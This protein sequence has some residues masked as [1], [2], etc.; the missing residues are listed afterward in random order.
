MHLVVVHFNVAS[1]ISAP[2]LEH[3]D[4]FAKLCIFHLNLAKAVLRTVQLNI[5]FFD[6]AI[7]LF[8]LL[9]D[10]GIVAL[11]GALQLDAL[12]GAH[13]ELGVLLA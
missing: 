13:F 5:F 10:G 4:F 9:T 3:I 8:D 1:Q 11:H 6:N 7:G 2:A 12:R